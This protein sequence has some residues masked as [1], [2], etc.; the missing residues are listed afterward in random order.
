MIKKE[1]ALYKGEELLIIGTLRE[2]AKQQ[3]IKERTVSFYGT[4]TY[5]KRSKRNRN[6]KIL[7]RLE[8]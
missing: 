2:I 8:D 5:Q 3:N 6:R 4:P 7:I 1:Y